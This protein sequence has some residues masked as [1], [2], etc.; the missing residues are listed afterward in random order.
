[1]ERIKLSET[2]IMDTLREVVAERPEHVYESPEHMRNG[3]ETCF[4]V[5]VDSE[6][7][8]PQPGCLVGVVLHRLGVPL[9][10]LAKREGSG[11]CVV[12]SALVET[13]SDVANALDVAQ[14]AQDCEKT[15]AQALASAEAV[16]PTRDLV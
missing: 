5:H 10:Q 2:Q 1:V 3:Y 6:G 4:Y 12:V 13:T 14:S 11:A 8:D 15:W 9:E 16:M 7:N